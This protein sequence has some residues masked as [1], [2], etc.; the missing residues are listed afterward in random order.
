MK[1]NNRSLTVDIDM[2]EKETT[3]TITE[4]ET[5]ISYGNKT[6]YIMVYNER[7]YKIW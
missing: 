4:N 7:R 3:V 6:Q 1:V 5:T 2:D